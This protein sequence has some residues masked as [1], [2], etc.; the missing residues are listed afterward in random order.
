MENNKSIWTLNVLLLVNRARMATCENLLR[1]TEDMEIKML[2][3]GQIKKYEKYKRELTFKIL[4]SWASSGRVTFVRNLYKAF[5][6]VLF[7]KSDQ[8]KS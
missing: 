6:V 8:S 5:A 4:K 7:T 3:A 2:Y 1:Q